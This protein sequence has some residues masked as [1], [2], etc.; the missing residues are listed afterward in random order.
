MAA[1][2]FATS[3]QRQVDELAAR[4]RREAED[5]RSLQAAVRAERE[6]GHDN[7]SNRST[8][9]ATVLPPGFDQELYNRKLN[10]VVQDVYQKA[11]EVFVADGPQ[12]GAAGRR[13][14]GSEVLTNMRTVVKAALLAQ[15]SAL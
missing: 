3:L 12:G 10:T 4:L 6:G 14:R 2:V 11:T 1:R 15:S 8:S 7:G 5:N 13:Y 9:Q